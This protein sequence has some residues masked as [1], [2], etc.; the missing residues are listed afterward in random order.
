M[1]A[2]WLF[3]LGAGGGGRFSPPKDVDGFADRANAEC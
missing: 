2:L 1:L 3:T